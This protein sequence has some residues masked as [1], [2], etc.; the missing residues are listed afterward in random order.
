MGRATDRELEPTL[1][2][3]A[4][5]S[6]CRDEVTSTAQ[7]SDGVDDPDMSLQ[8]TATLGSSS[9]NVG[10]GDGSSLEET[11]CSPAFRRLMRSSF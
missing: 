9:L 5:G 3:C 6:G 11:P 2:S 4:V 8:F 7:V 10:S 1:F